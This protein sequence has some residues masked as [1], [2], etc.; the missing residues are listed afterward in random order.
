M[1]RKRIVKLGGVAMLIVTMLPVTAAY[2]A[3]RADAAQGGEVVAQAKART[4][5]AADVP[6][7]TSSFTNVWNRT[8]S[9]VASGSVKRSWLWGP[10]AFWTTRELYLDDPTGTESRLV[11]Y[12]DKSRME[13]NNPNGNKNDPFYVTNGLLSVELISG[14]MQTGNNSFEDRK[15]AQVNIAGDFD[16][17]TAPTYASFVGKA[18]AGGDHP[19]LNNMGQ[20]V[21][22]TIARDGQVGVDPAKNNVPGVEIAYYDDVTKHNI[23]K[24]MWDFLNASGP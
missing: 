2:Q 12:W 5:Q 1:D 9:L 14:K 6:P 15:P 16:D 20:K 19:D 24:A 11:Q 13:I 18:N 10:Q 4:N 17:A 8:D 21:I 23:P 22:N 7:D 3:P